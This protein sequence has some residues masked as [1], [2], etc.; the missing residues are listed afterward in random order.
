MGPSP[1]IKNDDETFDTQF[2]ED[3]ADIK[4]SSMTLYLELMMLIAR[5]DGL[6]P[7]TEGAVGIVP[8]LFA[9]D[10]RAIRLV[11][12]LLAH[13]HRAHASI[14]DIQT[15]GSREVLLQCDGEPARACHQGKA[16]RSGGPVRMFGKSGAGD[17]RVNAAAEIVLQAAGIR[18]RQSGMGGSLAFG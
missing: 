9:R 3:S 7:R 16:K 17:C 4:E 5:T 15:R 8:K 11:L 12:P 10:R 6:L 18:P 14:I 2:R 1:E 13:E